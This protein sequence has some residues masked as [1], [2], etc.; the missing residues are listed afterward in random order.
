MLPKKWTAFLCVALV[1]GVVDR[2]PDKLQF[3]RFPVGAVTTTAS[4]L[5]LEDR[6]GKRLQRLI[7][8]QLMTAVANLGL[9]RCLQ[10]GVARCMADVTISACN[11]IVVVRP[12]VPSETNFAAVTIE[13]HTVLYIDGCLFVRSEFD[14]R[15][16][17]LSAP[18]PG[19]VCSAWSVTGLALQLAVPE[20]TAWIGRHRMFGLEYR[21][22]FRIVVAGDAGIGALS[23][24]L[25]IGCRVIRSLRPANRW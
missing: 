5:A 6:M 18:H 9:R 10:N 4:H 7:A 13:T 17:L 12:A 25:D 24:V 16:P 19:R 2:L 22:N 21:Q 23:A 3:G 14:D 8:L 1:T 15:R 11:F 20:R